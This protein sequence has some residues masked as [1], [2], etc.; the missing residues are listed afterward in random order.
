MVV[1]FSEHRVQVDPAVFNCFDEMPTDLLTGNTY[2]YGPV[3]VEPYQL[4]CFYQK[5]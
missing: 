2:P 5:K 4:L 1:N 3:M